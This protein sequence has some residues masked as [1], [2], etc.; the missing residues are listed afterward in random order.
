MMF[1][2]LSLL[3]VSSVLARDFWK[4]VS[5]VLLS[6]GQMKRMW[7]MKLSMTLQKENNILPPLPQLCMLCLVTQDKEEITRQ[8]LCVGCCK[9]LFVSPSVPPAYCFTRC[10]V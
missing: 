3:C 6:F 5:Y 8:G 10:P 7:V 2:S 9:V 1:A 4:I